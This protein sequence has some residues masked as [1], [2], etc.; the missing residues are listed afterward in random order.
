MQHKQKV[1]ISN[2]FGIYFSCI[3]ILIGIAI[4]LQHVCLFG[5]E[6]S[7]LPP[8][9]FPTCTL[10]WT[11]TFIWTPRVT[12]KAPLSLKLIYRLPG[13]KNSHFHSRFIYPLLRAFKRH[14][15]E[16]PRSTGSKMAGRQSL[17]CETSIRKSSTLLHKSLKN[18]SSIHTLNFDDLP[19]LSQLT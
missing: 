9:N 15:I 10:I 13:P 1:I 14:I 19:F 16:F 5:S 17:K 12:K 18:R 2:S 8:L 3:S 11:C 6:Y 7:T 4:I